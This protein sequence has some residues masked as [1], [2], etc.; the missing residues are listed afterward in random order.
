M[1][2]DAVT[3]QMDQSTY[4]SHQKGLTFSIPFSSGLEV[5]SSFKAGGNEYEALSVTNVA[6][7]DETLLVEA[8]EVKN[9]KPK[10]RRVQAKSG[11]EDIQLSDQHGR[12][13]A[14]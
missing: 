9:D 13:N 8:K 5:G 4:P 6:K 14:D 12:D 1:A 11:R 10:A 7:R 2:W 3:V